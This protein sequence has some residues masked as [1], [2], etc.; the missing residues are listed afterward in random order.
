MLTDPLVDRLVALALEEDLALGDVTTDATIDAATVGEGR[1]AAKQTLVVAGVDVSERVFAAVDSAIELEW[2]AGDG[3]TVTAGQTIAMARGSVRSLLKAERTVLN[4]M[5]RLSGVATLSRRFAD[6]VAGTD[7]RVVDTRKTTPGWR[8]LQKRAVVAG[9]CHNHRASLGAGVLIKDNHVDAGGGVEAAI[10]R[11]KDHAPHSLRVEIEV[12]T[13][14]ELE[15]AIKAGADVVLL[16]NMDLATLALCAKRARAAG[17]ISE[18]SGGVTLETV[19][20]VAETG[21]DLI[22]AGALTHSALS[23]DINMKVRPL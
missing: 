9:G 7:A 5:Q 13:P 19:R 2:E 20:Q 18:A 6:A 23:V 11:V 4:F 17:V 15:E 8:V 16:D 1:I 14:F 10:A 22:S 12:R 21:V 3:D